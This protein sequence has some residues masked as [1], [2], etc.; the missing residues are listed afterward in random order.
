LVIFKKSIFKLY[1]HRLY[2][3][4]LFFLII[5]LSPLSF[6]FRLLGVRFLDVKYIGNI[7]H[8]SC[9]PYSYIKEK[10]L[11]IIKKDYFMI[12]TM[13]TRKIANLF[14]QQITANA[15]LVEYWKGYKK[16]F[17][18]VTSPWLYLL[19]LPFR[20]SFLLKYDISDYTMNYLSQAR[21][22]LI[23]KED[24]KPLLKIKPHHQKMGKEILSQ[25]GLNSTDW[26]V[27]FHCRED[28]YRKN[29]QF[30]FR[31][32]NIDA[33]FLALK[34]I[35]KR[36]GWTIRLGRETTPLPE[37]FKLLK[38]TI[39]Y[40][41]NGFVSDWMDL[42]LTSQSK[43][44]L[45]SSTS[46]IRE[47]AVLFGTPIVC[48]NLL[49]FCSLPPRSID[50][51][52]PRLYF[53]KQKQR[54]LSFSEIIK[55]PSSNYLHNEE[56]EKDGI[57]IIE[58]T[59]E[60]IKEVVVEMLDRLDGLVLANASDEALQKRFHSLFTQANYCYGTTAKIGTFFLRKHR[61]LNLSP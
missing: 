51:A 18:I 60:E 36:G 52:I 35:E 9:E 43:F 13:P 58:N 5:I 59:E 33:L 4:L 25:W 57:Q 16:Y 41:Q 46:G 42:F 49:P 15:A 10:Q 21:Y 53:S 11:G 20:K 24:E 27:C 56:F 29:P 37:R 3:I 31:N 28:G 44:N 40:S 19:L 61:N 48:V 47:V 54:M 2:K 1:L 7:G 39:D 17:R 8:I 45:Y 55:S 30:S 22:Y 6:V 32:S 12:L 26:F 14:P 23:N 38:K 34:E 50:L